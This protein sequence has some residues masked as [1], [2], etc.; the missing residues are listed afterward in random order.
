MIK[1]IIF[2]I[3]GVLIRTED[4]SPRAAIEERLG[5]APGEAEFLVLNSEQGRQA[6]LGAV[7]AQEHWTWVQRRFGLTEAGLRDFRAAFWGGDRVDKE[8]LT[9]IRSL[10]P[11]YQ[12]AIISNAMDDL[13]ETV[14][15]LDPTGDLFDVVVGSAYEKVMKPDPIICLR[16]LGRQPAEALF[17]DD[18]AANIAGAQRVGLATIHFQP[19][20]DLRAELENLV[21][22]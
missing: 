18:A 5:L 22:H 19:G 2:D 20:I 13:N 11:R 9:Y 14:L 15:R 10:R 17:I 7:T 1:A 8:L 12:T 6:Q 21:Q 16:T 4:R 3:G